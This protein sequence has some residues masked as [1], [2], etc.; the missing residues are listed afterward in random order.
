MGENIAF[1][2]ISDTMPDSKLPSDGW[3]WIDTT[4]NV[5]KRYSGFPPHGSWV[6]KP[7][8]INIPITVNELHIKD[9]LTVEGDAQF[10]R[11]IKVGDIEGVTADIVVNKIKTMIFK[12]GILIKYE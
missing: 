10:N 11:L 9:D 8:D 5:V 2:I 4:N 3:W 7:L 1:V 6:E 12:N